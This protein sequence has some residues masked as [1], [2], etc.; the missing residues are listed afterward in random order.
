MV[1]FHSFLYVY[2]RVIHPQLVRFRCRQELPLTEMRKQHYGH[3]AAA[4]HVFFKES[5]I[6]YRITCYK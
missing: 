1:I 2:H 4:R 5:S 6:Q 3:S